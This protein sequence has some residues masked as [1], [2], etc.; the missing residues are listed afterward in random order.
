MIDFELPEEKAYSARI[1]RQTLMDI[2]NGVRKYMI[3]GHRY[4]NPYYNAKALAEDLG[5]NTRYLSAAL[6]LHFNCNFN[7]LVNRLRIDDAKQIMLDDDFEMSMEDLAYSAGYQ[8]RQTFYNA[9]AKYV[10]EKPTEWLENQREA[11]RI[12]AEQERQERLQ[13]SSFK[14]LDFD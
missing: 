3:V 7:E 9:F 10:G 13:N 5:V 6:K 4:R 12:A 8:T 14:G 1:N 11:K 2:K